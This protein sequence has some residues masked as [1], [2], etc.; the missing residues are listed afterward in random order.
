MGV[1]HPV[2]HTQGQGGGGHPA[3]RG[4]HPAPECPHHGDL[5]KLYNEDPG[6]QTNEVRGYPDPGL[7]IQHVKVRGPGGPMVNHPDDGDPAGDGGGHEEHP[8]QGRDGPQEDEEH[9]GET[10]E[11]EVIGEVPGPGSAHLRLRPEVVDV[12]NVPPPVFDT[13]TWVHNRALGSGE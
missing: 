13:M 2:H 6:G 4:H 1:I 3:Q 5:V 7:V 10:E 8:G 11:L 9:R 12:E